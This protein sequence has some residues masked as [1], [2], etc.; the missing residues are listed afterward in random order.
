MSV[1]S[2][3]IQIDIDEYEPGTLI[4]KTTLNDKYHDILLSLLVRV[5][6]FAIVEAA[7]D[8][9]KIPHKDCRKVYA[10]MEAM[11]GSKV[12]P[13]L[14]RQVLNTLGGPQG[15][16]NLV[17]LFLITAPLAI[18]AAAVLRQEKESLTEE[19]MDAIWQE[20]LAGVCV[21]YPKKE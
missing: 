16:P 10:L 18:N 21:A 19:Q 14:T 5:P 17:N 7:V 13:G 4:L 9:K 15:C 2:R 3:K 11:K 1:F 12:G 20:V 6:D 8:M